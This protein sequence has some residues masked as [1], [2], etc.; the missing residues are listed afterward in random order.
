MTA[1]F[2]EKFISRFLLTFV[3]SI[4]DTMESTQFGVVCDVDED[5]PQCRK[6]SIEVLA[7]RIILG[8]D[9]FSHQKW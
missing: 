3:E 7:L 5:I 4:K 1:Y 9:V 6:R 8:K 2:F